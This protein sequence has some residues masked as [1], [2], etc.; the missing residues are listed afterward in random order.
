MKIIFPIFTIFKT[1]V[2]ENDSKSLIQNFTRK[3]TNFSITILACF[4]RLSKVI[5]GL[6][7]LIADNVDVLISSMKLCKSASRYGYTYK[8]IRKPLFGHFIYSL[9]ELEIKMTHNFATESGMFQFWRVSQQV[10]E[11]KF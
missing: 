6:F 11:E 9:R 2:F 7:M 3:A 8:V 1:A 5:F 4:W 10:L